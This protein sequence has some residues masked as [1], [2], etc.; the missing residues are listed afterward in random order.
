MASEL[1]EK[2]TEV[3]AEHRRWIEAAGRFGFATKGVVYG[4]VGL[5]AIAAAWRGGRASGSE[6]AIQTLGQQPFGQVLL[7]L[8]AAGLTGHA[9]W[10]II[11]AIVGSGRRRS[12]GI[13]V[14]R[15]VGFLIS[16][17]IH[18]SLAIYAAPVSLGSLRGHSQ[19]GLVEGLLSLPG[20][21]IL[22]GVL[23]A[24]ILGFAGWEMYRA[25]SQKFMQD[26]Q[27]HK[28]DEARRNTAKY[29][30]I[31]GLAAR[32]VTFLIMGGF[33]I[34]AAVRLDPNQ[35]KGIGEALEVLARQPF[36]PWLLALAGLGMV[37][38]AIHC[39]TL[40][41]YRRFNLG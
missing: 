35:A 41:L 7:W 9:L 26:Y 14:L 28:M 8:V 15:R 12:L 23:G 38:Y 27:I 29:A 2:A 24:S 20:G 36:G 40:A 37:A 30:G 21:Q 34:L 32:G 6:G 1:Q 19:K 5:L 13:N 10:Q 25:W 16:S 33:I 18:V 22:V 11:Q 39:G 4:L 31:V 17:A 3:V